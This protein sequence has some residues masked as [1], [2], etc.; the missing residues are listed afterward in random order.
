MKGIGEPTSVYEPRTFKKPNTGEILSR[1]SGEINSVRIAD[2][3]T[4]G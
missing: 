2:K 3:P 1:N 4:E